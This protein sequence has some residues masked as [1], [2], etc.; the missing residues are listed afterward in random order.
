[1]LLSGEEKELIKIYLLKGC[2]CIKL[3][4]ERKR[5]EKTGKGIT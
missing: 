1:M 3:T 4:N 5:E 2:R